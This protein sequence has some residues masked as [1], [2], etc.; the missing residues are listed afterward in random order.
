MVDESNV[1]YFASDVDTDGDE[2]NVFA[3][4]LIDNKPS[5][6]I[7]LDIQANGSKEAYIAAFKAVDAEA[8]RLAEEAADLKDMEI[9]LEAE[10]LS[11][12]ILVEDVFADD[13]SG[14]AYDFNSDDVI[15][16][17]QIG[18]F[19]HNVNTN[20]YKNSSV[21]FNH[22]YDDGYNRFYSGVFESFNAA[23]AHLNQNEKKKAMMTLSFLD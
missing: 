7:K 10:S 19:M 12:I 3:S 21:L 2:L 6:P 4:E 13:L 22:R 15:Y 1:L 18:A 14:G 20:D 9:L 23:Q 11:E 8:M 17:V 5:T 16:T